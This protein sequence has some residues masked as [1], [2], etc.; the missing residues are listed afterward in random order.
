MRSVLALSLLVCFGCSS[1]MMTHDPHSSVVSPPGNAALS[2]SGFVNLVQLNTGPS[3]S[4]TV[5]FI[6][7]TPEAGPLGTLTFCGDVVHGFVLNTFTTVNFT[8]GL[9]CSK[10]VSIVPDTMMSV[11]G[12]VTMSQ[13]V[14]GVS[15]PQTLVVFVPQGGASVSETFCGDVRKQF[16]LDTPM[17]AL[18]IQG[19]TCASIISVS[20]A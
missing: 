5:T 1:A 14:S 13:P 10:I 12:V 19:Q 15:P 7:Q 16:T 4:T 17:T 9:G 2:V 8:Q 20:T 3:L 6:P 11:G 18:F